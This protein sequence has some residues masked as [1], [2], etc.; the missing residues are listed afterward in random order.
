MDEQSLKGAPKAPIMDMEDEKMDLISSTHVSLEMNHALFKVND[1]VEVMG[2]M[3][4]GIN[5]EGGV[6]RIIAVRYSEGLLFLFCLC[7]LIEIYRG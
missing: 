5:K 4:P 1:V 6:G 2:R 3:W 7:E